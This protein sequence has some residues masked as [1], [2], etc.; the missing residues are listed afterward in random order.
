VSASTTHYFERIFF[1][2][3]PQFTEEAKPFGIRVVNRIIRA[4]GIRL[5]FADLQSLSRFIP[6]GS[7]WVIFPVAN[8]SDV[9]GRNRVS[10]RAAIVEVKRRFVSLVVPPAGGDS[11]SAWRRAGLLLEESAILDGIGDES[12]PLIDRMMELISRPHCH[13]AVTSKASVR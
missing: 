4:V 9:D 10:R 11:F 13:L 2:P 7:T 6:A 12:C 5:S 3:V 8:R 1:N